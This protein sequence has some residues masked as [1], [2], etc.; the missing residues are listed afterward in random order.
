MRP[1]AGPVGLAS[2]RSAHGI[3]RMIP[4]SLTA[5]VTPS[6]MNSHAPTG[7]ATAGD[8]RR[9]VVLVADDN[10]DNLRLV[11]FYLREHFD[12]AQVSSAEA[13]ITYIENHPVDVAVLDLNFKG[14][15]NGIDAV[16]EIRLNDKVRHIPVMALTA[17]AFPDDQRRCME[18]GFDAYLA[19][20]VLKQAMLEQ[21]RKLLPTGVPDEAKV[22]RMRGVPS[23]EYGGVP[24]R[25]AG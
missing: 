4:R 5:I 21:V 25:K 10:P 1:R 8:V 19:K 7:P 13:A 16:K 20:P 22:A 14:G 3:D 17:Y 24:H 12:V 23:D 9:P 2:T 11:Y 15:M 6:E 18:A